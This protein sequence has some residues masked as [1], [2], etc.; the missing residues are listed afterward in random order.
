M[1]IDPRDTGL[2]ADDDQTTEPVI[3]NLGD[4]LALKNALDEHLSHPLQSLGLVTDNTFENRKLALGLTASGFGVFGQFH[5][6]FGLP[7]F[8]HDRNILLV[9]V[10]G[11]MIFSS[12]MTVA[13]YLNGS[14]LSFNIPSEGVPNQEFKGIQA[15]LVHSVLPRYS[16]NFELSFHVQ[17][18][19]GAWHRPAQHAE[20]G[21]SSSLGNFFA[22]DGEFLAAPLDTFVKKVLLKAVG[23]VQNQVK[24]S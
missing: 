11:Y 16:H 3:V 1:G 4:G 24:S 10:V 23:H 19:D 15:I 7:T 18:K 22:T 6:W 12:L 14:A 5:H 13:M 21:D 17:T 9:C 20:L 2:M 8:P